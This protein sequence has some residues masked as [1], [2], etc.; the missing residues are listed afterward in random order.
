MEAAVG[1]E[2]CGCGDMD[3]GACVFYLFFEI[4]LLEWES[5]CRSLCVLQ[6]AKR[7][8]PMMRKTNPRELSTRARN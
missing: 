3:M 8:V 1:V 6:S 4:R 2:G 7:A 5:L